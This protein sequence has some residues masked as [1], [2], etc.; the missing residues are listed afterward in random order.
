MSWLTESVFASESG[1]SKTKS[2]ADLLKDLLCS[3][4][5]VAVGK[6]AIETTKKSYDRPRGGQFAC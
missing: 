4:A 3:V 6:I 1:S 5:A 2:S